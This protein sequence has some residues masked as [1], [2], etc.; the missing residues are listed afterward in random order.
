MDDA[1][2]ARATMSAHELSSWEA[3]AFGRHKPAKVERDLG[4]RGDRPSFFSY[5]TQFP[6]IIFMI[7]GSVLQ[8]VL[9]ELGIS[10]GLSLVALHVV[11]D[12]EFEPIGHQLVGVLLAFLVV[13]RS[14]I[15]WNMFLEGRG[16]IGS[17]IASARVIAIQMVEDLAFGLSTNVKGAAFEAEEGVRLLK[18]FYCTRARRTHPDATLVSL[19]PASSRA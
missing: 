2:D 14:Q 5:F 12:E 15:A 19:T 6:N 10:V 9:I 1:P 16:H 18:L 13:F 11:P 7:K 4:Y 8:Y 3:A 17:L